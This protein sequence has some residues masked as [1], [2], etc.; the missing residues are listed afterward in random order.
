MHSRLRPRDRVG[1]AKARSRQEASRRLCI[2]AGLVLGMAGCQPLPKGSVD[3][4]TVA[5]GIGSG[6]TEL[7]AGGTAASA[8]TH[9]PPAG[10]APLTGEV[11]PPGEPSEWIGRYRD[12]RGQGQIIF[13]LVRDRH[14]LGG[15]WRFRTGE[16]TGSIAGDLA[17]DGRTVSFS[18]RGGDPDCP[19]NLAG[20]GELRGDE[21]TGSYEGTDCYGAV[22]GGSLTLKKVNR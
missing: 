1:V 9:A 4:V 18:M 14:A 2:G 13:H 11:T 5:L 22:T 15:T 19:A 12:S 6:D 8:K 10:A 7:Q 3:P 20:S 16:V 17:A 21:I